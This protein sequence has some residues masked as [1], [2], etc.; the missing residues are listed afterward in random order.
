MSK[1]NKMLPH[2]DVSRQEFIRL[3]VEHG[4]N[5]E[6]ASMHAMI[7]EGLGGYTLIGGR[8]LRSKGFD[9]GNGTYTKGQD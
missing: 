6:K 1:R 4:G 3:Y 2:V 9:N 8:M 7:S 5:P